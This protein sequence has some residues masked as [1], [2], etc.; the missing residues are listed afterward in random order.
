MSSTTKSLA[1]TDKRLVRR[2]WREFIKKHIAT[3]LLALVFMIIVAA[4]TAAYTWLLK[5]I[6]DSMGAASSDTGS[7]SENAKSFI[8]LIVPAVIGLTA[9]SGISL[10]IQAILT[11]KIALSVIADLQKKMFER[12]TR[13]DF[14]A[15][16]ALPVGKYVS[17][18][19]NDVNLIAQALLRVMNNLGR[20]LLTLVFLVGAMFWHNW[21]MSLVILLIYPFAIWPI[22]VISKKIRGSSNQAQEQMGKIN[23]LLNESLGGARM[24]RS[25]GLEE[26]ENKR[27]GKAFDERV[28]LYLQLVSNQARVDPI[29]EILAGLAIAGVFA[30]GVYQMS[31]GQANAGDLVGVLTA[32]GLAAPKI[33]ALGT[34]N[35]AVQEGLAALK[36]VFAILDKKEEIKNK[37]QANLLD[38]QRAELEFNKV[39]FSYNDGTLAIDNISFTARPDTITALVGPSGGGKSTIINLIPRLYDVSEGEIK[40]NGQ[41]IKNINLKSLRQN[42]ALVSQDTI[43][44][45]DTIAANI[46]FGNQTADLQA[47]KNAAKAAA[48]DEFIKKLPNGYDTKVGEN[49]SMLSGGQKQRIALARAFLKD[50]PILL[51]DEATSALDAESE[52][53]VQKAMQKLAKNRTVIVIAHRLATVK[54]ADNI[55]VLDSGKI[56]ESGTHASLVKQSGLYAR[57][58]NLQLS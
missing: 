37:E 19:T 47:I 13:M 16:T 22:I 53:K 8:K 55:I 50:A 17:H 54:A 14:A 56:I 26:Y 39:S 2:L 5:F 28:K 42:I 38:C 44:F 3:F 29:M 18:F 33:R 32:L 34:L 31:G 10:F 23:A 25:Y 27:L 51:L 36:R 9:I 57:L 58:R 43:L 46:G 48:A 4:A 12:L 15:L 41:N 30:F 6:V 52:A 35:N 11:N 20:D 24:V 7:A 21:Q 49:G 40:I 45:D 1:N